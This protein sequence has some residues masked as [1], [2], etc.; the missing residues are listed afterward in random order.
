MVI[1]QLAGGLGNQMFQ[2]A[3]YLQLKSLGKTVKIDDVAGFKQD[4]QRDPVLKYF[5]IEYERATEEELRQMLD[6]SM[7]PWAR[8][9]R[10]LFGRKK[11]SY[12]EADKRFHP[13]IMEW[14]D[15]YLEGYW[16]TEKYFAGVSQEVR[17]AYDTDR[18]LQFADA[19][20]QDSGE[21]RAGRQD[22]QILERKVLTVEEWMAQINAAESVSVHIRGGDYLLP[23]N[24]KLFGGICTEAYYLNAMEQMNREH[25]EC[26]FYIFTNDKQWIREKIAVAASRVGVPDGAKATDRTETVDSAE[27]ETVD[28][29]EIADKSEIADSAEITERFVASDRIKIV[30]LPETAGTAEQRDYAEFALMSRCRHH[31]LAN[32]SYSWWAS[33]LCRNPY[34]T[35]LVPDRW[36]NGWD[37]TDIYRED[38]QWVQACDSTKGTNNT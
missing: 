12:F 25:P 3:L 26:V 29:V 10:K 36:L 31:I 37:C 7:L 27:A 30:E 16:Q 9:R 14:D 32:S 18:L 8:V 33:Y 1:I 13:E 22:I 15:I 24:Q 35:V 11:K 38:M 17:A 6:S 20:G 2:Y 28:G 4:A 21:R 34:K 19:V 5:G 23:E